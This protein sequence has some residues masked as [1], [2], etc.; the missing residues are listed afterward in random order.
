MKLM[1]MGD[2]QIKAAMKPKALIA[3]AASAFENRRISPGL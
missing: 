2:E 3:Q 1:G